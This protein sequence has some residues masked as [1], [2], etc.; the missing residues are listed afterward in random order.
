MMWP[1]GLAFPAADLIMCEPA[2]PGTHVI[3]YNYP[4]AG[5]TKLS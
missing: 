3:G 1:M 4:G 5:F 2:C